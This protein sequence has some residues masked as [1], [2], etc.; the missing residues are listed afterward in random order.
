[1][2]ANILTLLI[3]LVGLTIL[4]I[5]YGSQPWTPSRTFE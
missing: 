3:A 5:R 2:K 1:M 4:G